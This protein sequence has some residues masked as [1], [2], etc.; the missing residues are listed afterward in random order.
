MDGQGHRPDR[1]DRGG[2]KGG[3]LEP[4]TMMR[5]EE[6]CVVWCACCGHGT[7]VAVDHE[8]LCGPRAG[9]APGQIVTL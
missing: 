3:L 9:A 2:P 7:R 5:A 6:G 8:R 4:V 1:P